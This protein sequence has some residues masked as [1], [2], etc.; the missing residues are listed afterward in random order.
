MSES[1][2]HIC[3]RCGQPYNWLE[4]R[5]TS[6][7]GKRRLYLYA[8]HVEGK[9][10]NRRRRSCYLGP[11]D[12]Y[13]YVTRMHAKE[14]LVLKPIHDQDKVVEYIKALAHSLK[15]LPSRSRG[16]KMEVVIEELKGLHSDLEEVLAELGAL[17]S[18]SRR[19]P[20][21]D[22]FKEMVERLAEEGDEDARKLLKRMG[23]DSYLIKRVL[24]V[25]SKLS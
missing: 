7:R 10:K 16:K 14:G 1:G 9:G 23:K 24:I 2:V 22:E 15:E 3:P 6:V 11:V 12:E 17:P 18:R 20:D 5:W 25:L 8:V 13:E 19:I 21:F 4:K